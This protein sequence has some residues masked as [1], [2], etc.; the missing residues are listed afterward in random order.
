MIFRC[1]A[2]FEK[3]IAALEKRRL[4]CIRE[5]LEG[6]QQ[7][8]EFHFHLTAPQPRIAPGKLHRI[9]NLDTWTVWKTELPVVGANLRPNQYPRV[10][11]AQDG[12][13]IAFLC[14]T[15]HTDNYND[16]AMNQLA[17]SRVADFF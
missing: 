12:E 4:R 14:I 15:G 5:S 9:T 17:L 1:H 10:W 3:E 16:E 8:C 7:L 2:V 11:F 6:F 13:M